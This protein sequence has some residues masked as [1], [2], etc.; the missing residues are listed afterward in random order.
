MHLST[1]SDPAPAGPGTRKTTTPSPCRVGPGR[2]GGLT[3]T[4]PLVTRPSQELTASKYSAMELPYSGS[5]GAGRRVH[6][7]V[8]RP[9]D[10]RP[11][12][13]LLRDQPAIADL[14][15]AAVSRPWRGDRRRGGSLPGSGSFTLSL[16]VGQSPCRDL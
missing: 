16:L 8:V 3:A 14:V 9:E 15:H 12:R 13:V 11:Y 2:Q 7:A 10:M 4:V 5:F 1:S 6:L